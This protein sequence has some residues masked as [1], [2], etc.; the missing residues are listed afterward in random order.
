MAP[1]R[2]WL[3]RMVVAVNSRF[4]ATTLPEVPFGIV[5][6]ATSTVTGVPPVWRLSRYRFR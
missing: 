4:E 5:L 2:S 3:S 1:S 6:R